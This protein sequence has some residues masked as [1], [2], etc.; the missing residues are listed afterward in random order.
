LN[1]APS[2]WI[3]VFSFVT[4]AQVTR[5]DEFFEK[6]VKRL[7]VFI[8]NKMTELKL[9]FPEIPRQLKFSHLK[10]KM[11]STLRSNSSAGSKGDGP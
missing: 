3:G 10:L 1:W 7:K 2:N 8:E 4:I 9:R 11:K 6:A 5:A